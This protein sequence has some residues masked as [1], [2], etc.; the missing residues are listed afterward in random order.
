MSLGEIKKITI[1]NSANKFNYK[2]SPQKFLF[3]SKDGNMTLSDEL[4]KHLTCTYKMLI[5][6]A[7]NPNN[8]FELTRKYVCE[9][10]VLIQD[11]EFL[12]M[13]KYRKDQLVVKGGKFNF[14]ELFKRHLIRIYLIK[15]NSIIGEFNDRGLFYKNCFKIVDLHTGEFY[16]CQKAIKSYIDHVCEFREKPFEEIEKIYCRM[17][18]NN[19]VYLTALNMP[20]NV[21]DMI[22]IMI[23]ANEFEMMLA[24]IE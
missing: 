14:N 17:K 12:E 9:K 19:N 22:N 3:K 21:N 18:I 15:N 6:S 5:F 11:D 13:N 8:P 1:Y 20:N 7:E 4:T 23:K 16:K 24:K 10:K 2:Y